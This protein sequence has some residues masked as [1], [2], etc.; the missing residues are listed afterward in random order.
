MIKRS[1]PEPLLVYI[2][3]SRWD[4]KLSDLVSAEQLSDNGGLIYAQPRRRL[5]LITEDAVK[6][7][8]ERRLMLKLMLKLVKA[9][10]PKVPQ[11]ERFDI[12]DPLLEPGVIL[13]VVTD[14]ARSPISSERWRCIQQLIELS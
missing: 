3:M 1:M 5:G 2:G 4:L 9:L 8:V 6:S 11:E 12:F 10:G 14:R 7:F 13:F